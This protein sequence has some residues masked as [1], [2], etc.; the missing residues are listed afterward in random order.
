[1]LEFEVNGQR[2]RIKGNLYVVA[3]SVDYLKARF[4][5][6]ADWDGVAKTAIFKT[7]DRKGVYNVI[8][9]ENG[10]CTV[11]SE[12]I[13]APQF[14]VSVF[15]G[16]RITANDVKVLCD[17][18]GYAVGNEPDEPTPEIYEQ[19]LAEINK[20]VSKVDGM[21]L[22]ENSYTTEEKEKLSGIAVGAEVNVQSD[23]NQ[24]NT[25]ADDY[26]K[27]K[28]TKL[29]QFENDSGYAKLSDLGGLGDDV[30]NIAT[31]LNDHKTA[32]VLDHPDGS[33]TTK[34]LAEGAVTKEK[35]AD[36]VLFSK[37]YD[38]L[39]NVPTKFPPAEHSHTVN[40]IS[41]LPSWAKQP[42]KPEYTA[43]EVGALP[44]DTVIPS[45]SAATKDADGL[46]SA[47]DKK[48]LDGLSEGGGG[49]ITEETD[50]TVPDWAKQPTKPTYTAAEVGADS[51]GSAASA[52]TD[53]KKYINEKVKTNVPENAVFTDTVYDDKEIK[54]ALSNEETVRTSADKTLQGNLDSHTSDTS[55]PHSVTKEQ[56][57][58]GNCNNTSDMD[59]PIST[60]MQT[61]LDKKLDKSG[62]TIEND[63]FAAL[64][65]KR[66]LSEGI[67]AI[68]FE[69]NDGVL[70][71]LCIGTVDGNFHRRCG[72]DTN[73]IYDI[74]DS[75]N[76]KSIIGGTYFPQSTITTA[77]DLNTL[78]TTGIY[79]IKIGTCTNVPTHDWGTL[80]VDFSTGTPYQ[81]Y[82]SDGVSMD[83][84]K[85]SYTNNTWSSWVHGSLADDTKA[86]TS[87]ASTA[88][89]YGI[90]TSSN[91]GHVKLSDSTSTTSGASAG[92]A[93][94]P[95][96]VK[97]AYDKANIRKNTNSTSG[98]IIGT[99]LTVGSRKSGATY[100]SLS[101][102]CGE[103]NEASGSCS[104]A[105]GSNNTASSSYAAAI[106]TNNVASGISSFATGGYNAAKESYATAMGYSNNAL[107]YQTKLGRYA[108]DGTYGSVSGTTGD[109]LTVGIGDSSTRKNGFRVDYS[110]NGYFYKAV[111]GTGADYAEMWEWLDGN[112]NSEDRVGYFVAFYGNKIRLANENDDLKK[113]GIISG[114]P[115]VIGD[116][117]AD[118]WQGMY[119]Q[120]V[121]GRN[122]TEHKIYDAEYDAEGNLIHEA[123]EADEFI[124]NPDYNPDE[125]Y[126]PRQQRKEWDAVGTHGKL[127]VRDNG[128]CQVDG[129]C[130]P[131]SGG[132]ATASED[133]F[134]VMERINDT[135]IRVYLK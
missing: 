31:A 63:T 127:V 64:S 38:D 52:L 46:M 90:G 131:A 81:I 96:A 59:K 54:S 105:V 51:D 29:S 21:G 84:Y 115:A 1:M 39:T 113:I 45:Y 129:F 133:G 98:D 2:L 77:T 83:I 47:A 58:L 26:I 35:I 30:G 7:A 69:N 99:H 104:F 34:K 88:T 95:T 122:I 78:K 108:A 73:K 19:I 86:P 85:R 87:H 33:V 74:L 6:S 41:N 135:L 23:W 28:P 62:G 16:S 22:S 102:T 116:N 20:K 89:T 42:E 101:F 100:G 120:D 126:I 128:S 56:V 8:L 61:A 107:Q 37:K 117:F 3:E 80:F 17:V 25:D 130:K 43:A 9:D 70:G 132:I 4:A 123:Y 93:A 72:S 71:Y 121:Y 18:S 65:I 10:I 119:L 57:G 27:N 125:K 66:T 14:Y 55:N 114:N 11:P 111:S 49:G 75:N 118:D 48:K 91:Y 76:Y 36:D 32:K 13:H 50:P 40:D 5:F 110:G 103:N 109:A 124:V 15:G 97:A 44:S 92:V 106:G 82:I 134:Y 68:K 12:V 60:A 24:T 112:P 94:T 67:A 53:A 79:H